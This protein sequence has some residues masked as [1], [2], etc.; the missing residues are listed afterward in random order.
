MSAPNLVLA[1]SRGYTNIKLKLPANPP[2]N[3]DI[4]KYR[5]LSFFEST[6]FK[7]NP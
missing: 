6:P 2:D 7:N 5:A 4:E 1:K 3:K